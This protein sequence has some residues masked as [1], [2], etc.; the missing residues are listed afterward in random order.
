MIEE[1]AHKPGVTTTSPGGKTVTLT[2]AHTFAREFLVGFGRGKSGIEWPGE[3]SMEAMDRVVRMTLRWLER[4]IA[5]I[6][7]R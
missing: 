5:Q 4:R 2:A 1:G 7:G 6:E 3:D